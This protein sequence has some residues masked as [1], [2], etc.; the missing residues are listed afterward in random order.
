MRALLALAYFATAVCAQCTGRSTLASMEP[1][2]TEE[3][4]KKYSM[5][6]R[7]T[8]ATIYD[9]ILFNDEL[10]MLEIR[11][12]ELYDVVDHIVLVES[13]T[14]HQN[15]P[16]PLH[17]AEN[18]GHFSRFAD[19][20]V[21]VALDDLLGEHLPEW[22]T[23]LQVAFQNEW[24]HRETLFREG[25]HQPGKEVQIGDLVMSGDLDEI[26]KAEAVRALKHCEWE[27]KPGMDDC[28]ALE[29][30]ISYFAYSWVAG[31]WNA[32]PRVVKWLG[33]GTSDSQEGKNNLRYHANCSLILE[34]SSWHCSDC[35]ATIAQVQRKIK[36]FCHS[37]KNRYPYNDT[38][39]I[40]DR[41]ARGL[42]LFTD[43]E[44]DARM[45]R[46]GYCNN[47]PSYVLANPGRFHYMLSRDPV[48]GSFSDYAD[49]FSNR[50][51][52]VGN[53][54][55]E[56]TVRTFEDPDGKTFSV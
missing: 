50:T 6:P 37:D 18:A 12:N 51:D 45:K 42:A 32:G 44:E 19:K 24:Y 38:Q 1:V 7:Q 35:F 13:A 43:K 25:L 48:T 29:G 22:F 16:K 20:I 14:T 30:S 52:V 55:G 8:P 54:H 11:L 31:A 39:F 41:F 53:F 56:W 17:Y 10:D 23:P 26:P 47:A 49:H 28:V 46:V 9:A 5:V 21:H 33:N 4:C 36:S 34:Q 27:P 3:L 15:Q 2:G 40:V